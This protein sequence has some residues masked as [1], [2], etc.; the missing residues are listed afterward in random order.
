M[1]FGTLIGLV[2]LVA[3]ISSLFTYLLTRLRMERA[4]AECG[5][6]LAD[7]VAA[8]ENEKTKFEEA[9]RSIEESTRR[10]AL[11]EFL[12]DLHI[13]ERRYVREHRVLFAHRKSL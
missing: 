9:A 6:A 8:L 11:D 12:A 10:K 7:A 4:S 1:N 5:R 2:A 13:E 3:I